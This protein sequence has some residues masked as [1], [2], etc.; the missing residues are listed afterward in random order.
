MKT[1]RIVSLLLAALLTLGCL[2]TAVAD[3]ASPWAHLDLSTYEEINFYVIGTLGQDWQ[4]V[5]DKANEMM[6]EKINTK[7]NFVPIP[8][9]DFIS[10][11][12]LYL[13]G[14]DSVDLIYGASWCN[15]MDF[16]KSGAFRGFDED[17]I[18][19]YMPLTAKQQAPSSWKE[20]SYDGLCYA[21]PN[22]KADI[23]IPALAIPVS[24][25][26]RYGR[27]EENVQT[28]EDVKQLYLE[29]AEKEGDSGLYAFKTNGNEPMEQFW[30]SPVNHYV[31]ANAGSATWMVWD[32]STGKPF[33]VNDLVWFAKADGYLDYCLQMAEFYQKGVFPSNI[34]NNMESSPDCLRAGTSASAF[35]SAGAFDALQASTEEDLAFI[36]CFFDEQTILLRGAY[37]GYGA[38]FPAASKKTERAAVALDCMKND[39]EVN[40]LLNMGIEGRHYILNEDGLTYVDGPDADKWSYWC[41]L[42]DH[43]GQ[44]SRAM[45]PEMEL[46]QRK[47]ESAV[48]PSDTFPLSGFVYDSSKYEAELAVLSALVN[49]YRYSFNFGIFGDKT[50]E[51][52][53]SFIQQCEAAGLDAIVED[54]RSQLSAYLAK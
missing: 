40:R 34:I 32:Y 38:C 3:E 4:E 21:V 51:K 30:F 15:F 44:P 31:D 49:E 12:S 37:F 42:L 35:T 10:M 20:V 13:S 7:V 9:S 33:D 43:D 46:Q 52:Y 48:V 23:S 25:L 36:D 5:V 17:F 54:F 14:D 41:F 18:R 28:I 53:R 6:I 16:V 29:I 22:N 2:G 19:T 47:Y 24:V 1:T 8:W 26:E 50:E 27:S 45:S 11:Y 39:P